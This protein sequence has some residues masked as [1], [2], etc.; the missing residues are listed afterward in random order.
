MSI[1]WLLQDY[2]SASKRE[3]EALLDGGIVS[4]VVAIMAKI[5]DYLYT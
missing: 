5:N 2:A 3:E 1:L 4:R